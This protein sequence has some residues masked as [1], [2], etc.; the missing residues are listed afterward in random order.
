MRRRQRRRHRTGAAFCGEEARRARALVSVMRYSFARVSAVIRMRRQDYFRQERR[1]WL[2]LHEKG[3]RRRRM[4]A[5]TLLPHVSGGE[6]GTLQRDLSIVFLIGQMHRARVDEEVAGR[7]RL[8]H[9][10]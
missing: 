2:R 4:T 3:G 8:L 7:M 5:L 1:G 6:A 9:T 10:L